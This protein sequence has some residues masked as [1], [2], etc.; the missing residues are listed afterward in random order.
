MLAMKEM[1]TI[2]A[3]EIR[4]YKRKLSQMTTKNEKVKQK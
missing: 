2:M 4:L 3:Q 1:L